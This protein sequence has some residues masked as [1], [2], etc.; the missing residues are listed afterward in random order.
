MLGWGGEKNPTQKKEK[1][2]NKKRGVRID[3]KWTTS[4]DRWSQKRANR[5]LPRTKCDLV[6]SI[7]TRHALNGGPIWKPCLFPRV[8][9]LC[10]PARP[11]RCCFLP[12]ADRASKRA[13]ALACLL[14]PW[15]LDSCYKVLE[16]SKKKRARHWRQPAFLVRGTSSWSPVASLFVISSYGGVGSRIAL[17]G[18]LLRKQL[19]P[20]RIA[21]ATLTS[22][23]AT[24]PLFFFPS[25]SLYLSLFMFFFSTFWPYHYKVCPDPPPLL[26]CL[27]LFCC[28]VAPQIRPHRRVHLWRKKKGRE[29][30]RR[31]Q[32]EAEEEVE[33]E[34]QARKEQ[35]RAEEEEANFSLLWQLVLILLSKPPLPNFPLQEESST[36][37]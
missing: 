34:E 16:K 32:E 23:E 14:G 36:V 10:R 29:E 12:G 25:L 2:E 37:T 15:R 11:G 21:L 30:A 3:M 33:E 4:G 6:V 35:E 31:E 27:L 7:S 19:P 5:S 8:G 26:S 18:W 1:S 9:R 17:A 13:R 22:L 28:Q 24:R 20:R